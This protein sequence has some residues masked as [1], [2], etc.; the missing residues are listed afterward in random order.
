MIKNWFDLLLLAVILLYFIGG[1]SSGLV[2]Q[3]FDV[4]GLVIIILLSIWGGRL[5]SE[6]V[7]TY[8][9]PEDIIPYHELIQRLGMDAALE[10]APQLI[11]GIIVFLIL[12]L[13]ISIVFRLF[14]GSFRWINRIPVIGFFN[15]AGGAV[16]GLVI[17]I[18]VVY[19]LI[20]AVSIIP[21]PFFVDAHAQSNVVFFFQQY[22]T[23]HTVMLRETMLNFY[24][25]LN[26]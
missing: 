6:S 17:G 13:F 15:R 7:A 18:V 21:L 8:I 24:L 1:I 3:L 26:I 22:L 9:N 23:P 14:S 12:F 19:I 5:F 20:T 11:A 2:K 25:S 4:F 16:S 10:K